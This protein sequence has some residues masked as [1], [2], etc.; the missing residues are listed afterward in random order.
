M[1]P[2]GFFFQCVASLGRVSFFRAMLLTATS[3]FFTSV[4]VALSPSVSW[5]SEGLILRGD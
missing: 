3:H 5:I 4:I 1:V 2:S